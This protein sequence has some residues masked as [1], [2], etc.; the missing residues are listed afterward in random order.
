LR[1]EWDPARQEWVQKL[2]DGSTIVGLR[3]LID[4]YDDR[5]WK[6][7][8]LFPNTGEGGGSATSGPPSSDRS[9]HSKAR[10]GKIKTIAASLEGVNSRNGN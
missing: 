1:F 7:V 3:E 10:V 4:Y 9:S 6:L 8:S 5:G 2:M